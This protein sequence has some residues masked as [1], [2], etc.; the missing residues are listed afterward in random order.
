LEYLSNIELYFTSS[1]SEDE[2]YLYITDDELHHCIK[3]MRNKI[4][5]N[6]YATNGYGKIFKG[7]ISSLSKDELIAEVVQVYNYEN[8]LER[9]TFCIPNLK[10]PERFKFAVEKCVELGITNFIF[11]P[12]DH[13]I[14]KKFNKERIEKI[15]LSS[16]KQSL[17][18]FLPKII[19]LKS[20]EELITSTAEIILFDQLSE[21]KI[22]D[23]Q[24][25]Q[26]KKYLFIFGPEGGFSEKEYSTLE[27]VKK[28]NLAQNRL[29]SE[30]AIIKAASILK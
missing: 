6:L 21:L 10:N 3:V 9:Y 1:I 8:D 22:K 17:R 29:R 30:T 27:D 25:D 16:M 24:F 28:I 4:G 15:I 7:T 13:S 20:I 14:S 18:A 19:F 5:D 23:F 26:N 11:Y 12:A 2:K